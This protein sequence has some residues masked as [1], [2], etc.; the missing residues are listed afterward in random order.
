[1]SSYGMQQKV[2]FQHCDPAGIVFYPRY[3]EMFNST[4]EDWFEKRVG[5][6]FHEIHMRREE[7]VPTVHVDV[8]FKAPSRLGEILT[9]SLTM[10]KLGKSSMG[11]HINV[12][13]GA[14]CRVQVRLTLVYVKS[15]L[16][17]AQG[18][19]DD[20]RVALEK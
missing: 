9:F 2:G 12:S 16:Q 18:W 20:L 4:V 11:L 7:A 5:F 10:V 19:P 15:G 13:H 1:M 14:E 8:D 17:K 3:F 6:S